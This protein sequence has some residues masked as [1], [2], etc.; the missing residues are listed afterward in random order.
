MHA[1]E[2]AVEATRWQ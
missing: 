2:S 1:S